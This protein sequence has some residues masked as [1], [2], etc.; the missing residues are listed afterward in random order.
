MNETNMYCSGRDCP[1]RVGCARYL[2]DERVLKFLR[3]MYDRTKSECV[4]FQRA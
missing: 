1:V 4:N 2:S 3:P